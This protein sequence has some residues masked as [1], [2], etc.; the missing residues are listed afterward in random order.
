MLL[1]VAL[2]FYVQA[3]WIAPD[4]QNGLVFITVPVYQWALLFL[5]LAI[6]LFLRKKQA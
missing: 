5:A 2:A 6:L 4:P 1:G 3:L